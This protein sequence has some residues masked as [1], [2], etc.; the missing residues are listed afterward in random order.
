MKRFGT[1]SFKNL[2]N[3]ANVYLCNLQ[4]KFLWPGFGENSRVLEW[5]LRRCDEEPCHQETPLGYVPK[6]GELNTQG[7]GD[8]DMKSLFSIPQ[9]FWLKEV[10][11]IPT[12]NL[13][14]IEMINFEIKFSKKIK[15]LLKV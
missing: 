7:L 8:I 15:K 11:I 14:I 1:F 13:K 4:G 10:I 5:V 9:D 2:K 6:Q 12:T 3:Y